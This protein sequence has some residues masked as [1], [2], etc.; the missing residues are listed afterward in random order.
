[1][2]ETKQIRLTQKLLIIGQ[3]A[4]T[5]TNL[6]ESALDIM[7]ELRDQVV[8]T[9]LIGVREG[10]EVVVLDEAMG[11]RM[12]CFVSK[13]GYR[14]PAYCSAPGKAMLAFLPEKER[15][16]VLAAT[17]LVR[18]NERTITGK[19]ELRR[20]LATIVEKGYAFDVVSDKEPLTAEF[21]RQ[22]N[23]VVLGGLDDFNSGRYYSP[24]GIHLLNT[25][26]NVKL[27][28]SYVA[29]G[30]GLVVVP[31][32]LKLAWIILV[33]L[34]LR[35][36]AVE[37]FII[38]AKDFD[39]GNV[40]VSLK[41]Q[42]FADEHS[43]IWHGDGWPDRVE[44]VFEFPLAGDYTLSALY[45]AQ[46][47]RPVEISV[48]GKKVHTGFANVTGSWQTKTA[49]WEKQ[50]TLRIERG[51]HNIALQRDDAFPHIC[52]LRFDVPD[53]VKLTCLSAE[54]RAAHAHQARM[55]TSL[56]P[57]NDLNVEAVRLAIDD[58][59][60]SFPGRYDAATHRK[61]V[62]EF[63]QQRAELVKAGKEI[64]PDAL[65]KIT[66]G[67]STALLANPLLD[68]D[69][70]LVVRRTG[71][72]GFLHANYLCHASMPR[73]GYDNEIAVLTN[74]R[75]EPKL[76]RLYK[77]TDD[78]VLRDVHLDF[79][80]DRLLFS[81]IDDNK[82]WAV[83]QIRRDG[84]GFQQLTPTN[85]P[86]LDFF[87]ACYLPNGKLIVASTANYQG[88]PCL[89]GD[90]QVASLYLLDPAT[91]KLRQLTF[92]QD[93]GNDPVVLND[94]RVSYQRWEY[95]DIP[96]Y[97]SRRRMTM[98]PD[99]TSQLALYGSN[100]WFP[101]AF[102]F[103][104]PVPDHPTRMVGIISGHHDHADCGRMAL[105]NPALA[106]KYPFRYRPTS[107]EW[108]EEGKPIAVTPD[109][110][111]AEQTGFLQ[112][113]PGR[114]KTV[115]GT[116]CDAIISHHYRKESPTLTTHPYPLSS[117]YFLV[118]MKTPQSPWGIYLV[119]IFDN[120]TL[121]AD[122]PHIAD[123]FEPQPFVART[124]PPVIPDRIV[125]DSKTAEVHIANIYSG[126]GLNGVPRGTINNVRVF[127]YHFG[128]LNRA[129]FGVIG[130]E[131]GWD[132]KRILGT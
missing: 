131:S 81:S 80:G 54:Q 78:R 76:E 30:G 82:R 75:G 18:F 89:N 83:F 41:G 42:G 129:G 93:H 7:R 44:Y 92:D 13:L 116:V 33:A 97:F 63:E 32:M 108:G 19:E 59:E 100:S 61:A 45:A 71:N 102:R 90:P 98:N 70:L 109:I 35:L 17:K 132:V 87:D 23:T 114:G 79:D 1:D 64:S 55:Q 99:G 48:D 106:G 29:E 20:E 39:A 14:V 26:A 4:I 16:T 68:F 66:A 107:K 94:G 28:Q 120:A 8:D 88:V 122:L 24:G 112:L 84:T 69:K 121:I 52:A 60:K 104:K 22:F 36:L 105:I 2:P 27:L 125:P 113:I 46:D 123:L 118:T 124:H 73:T 5:E 101:T 11:S 25:A 128:Y 43:C 38:E 31:L 85:Y 77:P 126:P 111:P 86:D 130:T 103:A 51:Q 3:R 37:E 6:V 96:H 95:S 74:L 67:I 47:S 110:L 56:A 91:G 34:P 9:V 117:K 21:L 62:A 65:K 40:R 10:G 119:D 72:N 50:C 127:A 53:G 57:L 49:K 115:A 58:M 12:F 15:D